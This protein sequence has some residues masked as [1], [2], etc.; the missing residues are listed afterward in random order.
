MM[1]CWPK[2]GLWCL[3]VLLSM[4]AGCASVSDGSSGLEALRDDEVV[5]LFD[6]EAKDVVVHSTFGAFGVNS[7]RAVDS[8]TLI[9]DTPRHG[10]LVATFFAPCPGIR[11]AE[12]LGFVTQGPFDLDKTTRVILP[13][14]TRCHFK[15]LKP[16]IK[17]E[18]PSGR[19]DE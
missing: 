17:L 13:D 6:Q 10:E 5:T 15:S 9:I 14:G 2:P 1:K 16:L 12:T 8:R 19:D 18:E 7:W 3:P 11:Y 4:L